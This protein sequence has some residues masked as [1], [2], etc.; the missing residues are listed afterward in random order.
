MDNI[1]GVYGHENITLV[2]ITIS[3]D[4]NYGHTFLNGV[5]SRFLLP[6]ARIVS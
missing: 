1:R 4:T 5:C 3:S 6:R 2:K